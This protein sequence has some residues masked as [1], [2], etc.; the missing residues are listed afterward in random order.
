MQSRSYRQTRNKVLH[1]PNFKFAS[2]WHRQQHLEAGRKDEAYCAEK[3]AIGTILAIVSAIL[4]IIVM[5]VAISNG[6]PV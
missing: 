4:M 3:E 1:D 5:V 6:H 2:E